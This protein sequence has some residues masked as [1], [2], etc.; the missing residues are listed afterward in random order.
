MLDN[1]F[2]IYCQSNIDLAKSIVIK[3]ESAAKLIN[4][5][6]LSRGED[7]DF[8]DPHSWKYYVNLN[9]EYYVGN[10]IKEDTSDNMMKIRTTEDGSLVDLTKANLAANP[11][12]KA[13]YDLYVN[14]LAEAYP[15]QENFIYRINK[16]IDI[17]AAVD[18]EEFQILF[19][20][21]AL[22][23][24]NE[25]TLMDKVQRWIYNFRDRW[26]KEDFQI[27]DRYYVASFLA[28]MYQKLPLAI[29]GF[30]HEAC[31][32]PEVDQYHLWNYLNDHYEL[33][34]YRD[35]LSIKQALWLYR[36]MVDIQRNAGK[37]RVFSALLENI[38]RPKNLV[39][40]KFD[41]VKADS[42]DLLN[43]RGEG[44]YLKRE[45]LDSSIDL[46]EQPTEDPQAVLYKTRD[47]ALKNRAELSADQQELIE[48][49]RYELKDQLPTGIIEFELG[50]ATLAQLANDIKYRIEYWL[51]LSTLNMY[52]TNYAFDI[53]NS[54]RIILNA[55]DAFILYEYA[56]Y[57]RNG[58]H[59]ETIDPIVAKSVI[60]FDPS[61]SIAMFRSNVPE[62]YVSDDFITQ[63][64]ANRI[65]SI[66]VTNSVT[67]EEYAEAVIQR[68]IRHKLSIDNLTRLNYRAHHENVIEG[69]YD[70]YTCVL[71]P[72]GTTFN[73]WLASKRI[74]RFSL[75]N[76][77]WQTVMLDTLFQ[78]TGIDPDNLGVGVSKSAMIEIIDRLT[79]YNLIV[80]N[81]V[82]GTL[83]NEMPFP[84]M[85]PD[86]TN[87]SKV[88]I[89]KQDLGNV[90]FVDQYQE[91]GSKVARAEIDTSDIAFNDEANN[92]SIM[93]VDPC[94]DITVTRSDE[95]FRRVSLGSLNFIDEF[96]ILEAT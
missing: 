36:N 12:T 77:D 64:L 81:G 3:V 83:I 68:R 14:R 29:M 66:T 2:K 48:K 62:E 79:S 17:N 28:V 90:R 86:K 25:I 50:S 43:G 47:K 88:A 91:K 27:S 95:N 56:R 52:N 61:I 44:E 18:A 49:G 13:N 55:K 58:V 63:T 70:D 33:G 65:P 53:P 34:K 31:G 60:S 54:G 93:R 96:L 69:I 24:S 6:L 87:S 22:V 78:C 82:D 75:T 51:Y 84:F 74:N 71:E 8:S 76:F 89:L 67:L 5:D 39:A 38:T 92:L 9:G 21:N 80:V 45:Y 94:L 72:V 20:D 30:R 26:F 35:Y 42:Q 11:L 15:L 23:A 85:Y 46:T 57:A 10:S 41:F 59:V 37:K 73:D 16:P 40:N 7:V 4:L 32:T 19:Y 1:D